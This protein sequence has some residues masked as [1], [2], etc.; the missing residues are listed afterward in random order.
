MGGVHFRGALFRGGS[1]FENISIL[2]RLCKQED[3][4]VKVQVAGTWNREE[5][6]VIPGRYTT[7]KMK[8]LPLYRTKN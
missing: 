2:E 4:F 1:S 7:H 3:N 5:S 6:L 8:Q